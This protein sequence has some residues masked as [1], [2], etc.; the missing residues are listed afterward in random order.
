MKPTRIFA[1]ASLII[2]SVALITAASISVGDEPGVVRMA[3]FKPQDGT[4][5]PAPTPDPVG[6]DGVATMNQ[7][8]ASSDPYPQPGNYAPYFERSFAVTEAV[9]NVFYQPVQPFGPIVMFE[10]NINEGIGFDNGYQR[11][12]ARLPYHIIPNTNVLI[13]DLSAS[14]TWDG[15]PIA[16]GG[17]VYR[18]Y[19]DV[20]NRIFGVNAFL[21]YDKGYN[22]NEWYRGTLGFESLGRYVDLRAN[23][24]FMLGDDTSILSNTLL[25]GL[26]LQGNNAFKQRQRIASNAYS[27]FDIETGGP[28]PLLGQYGQNLYGGAYYLTNNN[29]GDTVGFQAR[30]E[31]LITQNLTVNTRLTTDEKF[32]TNVWTSLQYEIPNYKDRRILRPHT[33]VRERLQD[34]VY[35]H[36]RVHEN[37]DTTLTLEALVNNGEDFNNNGLLDAGEDLDCDGIL[38]LGTALP[39]FLT[40]V[41]PNATGPGTGTYEDPFSTLQA[42]ALVNNAGID[43]IRIT[44]RA[45]DSGTGLTVNGGLTLFDDQIVLS[46][47]QS[48]NLGA[49][50]TV[51]SVITG[52]PT[53]TNLGPLLS[54]PTMGVGGSVIHLANNNHVIGMRLNAA[55]AAGTVFGDG[56][57]NALPITNAYLTSNVVTNYVTGANLQDVSGKLEIVGN[58]FNGLTGVSTDGLNLSAAAGTDVDLLLTN[59]TST[60]NSGT[61]FTVIAKAGST[62]EADDPDGAHCVTGILD[63]TANNNGTGFRTEALAGATFSALVERN[64]ATGNTFNGFEATSDGAASTYNLVSMANNVFSNNLSNGAFIHFLNGGLF[65]SSTEDLDGD[66]TLD[67]GEDLNGNERLDLGIVS[68]NMNQNSA[69]GLSILGEDAS[70]G[71]FDIGGP[72]AA[73][74]NRFLGNNLAG[75]STDLQDTSTAKIN[76]LF[77]TVTGSSA[78]APASFTVVLDFIDPGQ[79]GFVDLFGETLNPFDVTNYGF[80]AAQYDIVTNAVL[81]T[82]RN[83]Y[84]QIPTATQDARSAIPDGMELDIDFVIGDNGVAPSNG[85]TEYYVMNIGDTTAGS[86]A[87][88]GLAILGAMRNAAGNGPNFV[89]NGDDTGT[90]YADTLTTFGP[91][92]PANAFDVRAQSLSDAPAHAAAALTSGNLTFTRRALGLVV[93]HEIG[94]NLS[95]EH[96]DD[97]GAVTPT[98][99]NPIMGTPAA[100]FLLPIQTLIEPAEFA[101]SATHLAESPADTTHPQFD[102]DQLVAAVGLRAA[103]SG[104]PTQNGIIVNASDNARLLDSTFNNNTITAASQNGISVVMNDSA[105]ADSVTIQSNAIT[106]GGGNGIN[107]VADGANAEITR[108][109]V[110][111]SGTNVYNGTTFN[112][113]N[114]VDNNAGDGFRAMAANGGIINGNLQNNSLTNNLGNGASLRIDNGGFVDFGTVVNNRLVRGNTITGNGGAGLL[115]NQLTNPTTDAQLDATVVGNTLSNNA[116][117]GVL[118]RLNGANNNPPAPPAIQNNNR[119]NLVVGGA[120]VTDANTIN[121][122]GDV[123]IG[124]MVAGNGNA[125]VTITN[126]TVTGTTNGADPLLN[127]SGIHF[128]R[129]DSSLLTATLDNITSTGNAGDGLRVEAQGGDKT[130][131]NLPVLNTP[132]TVTVT[133]SNFSTNTLSGAS[134]Q[135]RGDATLIGDI[136]NSQVRNNGQNG[137]AIQTAENSS[138]G[139]PTIGLPPGRRSVFDGL[140]VEDN[141]NDGVQV[142]AT[143][144]SRTLLEINSTVNP[145][146]I[147]NNGGDGVGI[148]TTGGRSDILITSGIL[149]GATT[150]IAGNGTTAGGNGVRWDASGTSE[151]VVRITKTDI[152]GSVAGTSEDTNNNGVL[153]AG[154]DLNSNGDIDVAD[155]DGIQ[156]NFSQNATATLIVGNIGEGNRIQNNGDDGIAV[157]ATG[158]SATGNP[159]PIITITDNIIG[160]TLNGLQAGNGGDGVSLNVFGGTNVGIAS[161]AVDNSITAASPGTDFFNGILGV[162]ETGAIPQFTMTDNIVSNNNGRGVNIALTGASGRRD[163][164]FGSAIFDPVRIRLDNNTIVSNGA[165][166]ISYRAD[167]NMN[168]SRFVFLANF[169]DPPFAGF[170]NLNFS[171]FQAQFLNL[172]VGSING[173]TAYLAPYLNLRTVQNSLFTVTN[174]TVQNNGVNGVTGE[175][176]RIDVGT[177]SYVA[178]DIRDNAFGGNL[179]EDLVTSSFLSAGNTFDSVNTTGDLTFDYV[180]LD[181]TAQLDMRFLNNSGNQVAPSDFGAVYT[182]ADPLKSQFFGAIGVTLREAALFQVDNGP[183]LNNPNNVFANFGVTQDIQAAFTTGNYNIR[184]AA[185]PAFPN[186]GFAPFLP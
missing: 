149:P 172:N 140:V 113:G 62:I 47:I 129:A 54:N 3:A 141:G 7:P 116:G 121:A 94:H 139:D 110:G 152:T 63:N 185:D 37:I 85:A 49:P 166:G 39:Y 131:P 60:N 108:A 162:T 68:N 147:S 4:A 89:V 137:I 112:Q 36:N 52:V 171:P 46:S 174:N 26:Q 118:S 150:T 163:R 34:P 114:T 87:A 59:N 19:D 106:N 77:N 41:N 61:G 177:G 156:A 157:T 73:L 153:D 10:T 82:V 29:G 102:I 65:T 169:P 151:G 44:P 13:T 120:A 28:V 91:L 123:G 43:I 99:A 164:E 159:R 5:A 132:N 90:V 117:G 155:G 67:A 175:G 146:S 145:T 72:A 75:V 161:G 184:A 179:Q 111:G 107:L 9:P 17:L 22:F 24:Y 70:N 6:S 160:G 93:S 119:L 30:W 186:L 168:Q 12:N 64:T 98:G 16:N 84:R 45:D 15:M 55:N 25:A 142:T 48:Y 14:V 183:N 40:H 8:P 127:G 103:S 21:D 95:L 66:G 134:F 71:I 76:A 181:D 126:T 27:G 133:D 125:N 135:T 53:T 122:N 178:A 154:E 92:T 32:G 11:I 42:A 38:D 176:I 57:Q 50:G 31:A 148:T 158:S 81:D 138:F 167:S 109:N 124:V 144:N 35:R 180:Y 170:N 80:G 115:L 100:P 173:N 20:Y 128:N 143:Q 105:V 101:F 74:G 51:D 23:G 86:T 78:G 96:V 97:T 130:D 18:R 83:Y 33:S 136:S 104:S 58:Q 69:A 88:G 2:S 56:V 165:E 1:T 182:N 79:A